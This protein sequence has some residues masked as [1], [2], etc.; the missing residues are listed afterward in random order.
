MQDDG[1]NYGAVLN[2]LHAA[3]GL[4]SVQRLLRNPDWTYRMLVK[5]GPD[6]VLRAYKV[7]SSS[8]RA[9]DE[10]V[11][12]AMA[13]PFAYPLRHE[14]RTQVCLRLPP[15]HDYVVNLTAGSDPL[16]AEHLKGVAPKV[17]AWYRPLH[18]SNLLNVK[19]LA[20]VSRVVSLFVVKGTNPLQLLSGHSDGSL[21]LWDSATGQIV[22]SL[23]KVHTHAVDTII[24][25]G[26]RIATGSREDRT[27]FLWSLPTWEFEKVAI[28]PKPSQP[29]TPDMLPVPEFGV[30]V[31]SG[32][33]DII[34][35]HHPRDGPQHNPVPVAVSS[36]VGHCIATVT[37][38]CTVT[39]AKGFL[40]DGK[41][42]IAFGNDHGTVIFLQ[43]MTNLS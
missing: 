22:K 1:Y 40:L 18:G 14:F 4:D 29:V 35:I 2:H 27:I 23:P 5:A 33:A 41:H 25:S 43:G 15:S 7:F 10:A 19:V 17:V 8:D 30:H 6:A 34:R 39:T 16:R 31:L 28:I 42:V 37:P 26:E 9:L 3:E 11:I 36:F 12:E 21:H 13:S 38:G 24:M 32:H 20:S